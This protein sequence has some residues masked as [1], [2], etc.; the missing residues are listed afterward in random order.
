MKTL[1]EAVRKWTKEL[2]ESKKV[3]GNHSAIRD[4][5][6]DAVGCMPS[7][8]QYLA[9]LDRLQ[10]LGIIMHDYDGLYSPYKDVFSSSIVVADMEWLRDTFRPDYDMEA[11]PR[12]ANVADTALILSFIMERPGHPVISKHV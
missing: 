7:D 4:L 11:D 1:I 9:V 2:A 3:L 12:V 8:A 5:Y 10:E 6:Y